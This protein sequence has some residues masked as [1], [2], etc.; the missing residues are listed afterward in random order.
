MYQGGEMARNPAIVSL[1]DKYGYEVRRTAPDAYH[2]NSPAEV[3]HRYIVEAVS[4]LVEGHQVPLKPWPY[5][6]SH[7]I[8]VCGMVPHGE[9][10]LSPDEQISVN[11]P[12]VGALKTFGCQVYI[13]PPQYEKSRQKGY[14]YWIYIHLLSYIVPGYGH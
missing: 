13:R 2:Q 5:A 14:F 7:Y 9:S 8:K 12:G 4:Y 11:R 1:F 6:L 10:E 3:P